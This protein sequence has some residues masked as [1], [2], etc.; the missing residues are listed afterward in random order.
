MCGL[1]FS[2]KSTLSRKIA[3]HFDA[4]RVAFDELWAEKDKENHIPKNSKGWKFIRKFARTEASKA[5]KDSISVVY[6]DNNP[7]FEHREEFRNVANELGVKE[8]VIYMNTP[9]KVIRAREK[10]NKI[11]QNRHQVISSNFDKVANDLEI[12]TVKENFIEFSPNDN[13]DDFFKRLSQI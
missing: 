2:G 9:L 4:K 3:N 13:L 6:D 7:K 12:P 8:I 5:L 11:S 10:A 1:A